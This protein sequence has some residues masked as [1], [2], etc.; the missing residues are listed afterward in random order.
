MNNHLKNLVVYQI[1]P[2]TFHDSNNDGIGDLNGI[3]TKISYFKN[4]GINA[5]WLC[6]IF[7]SPM[8]DNGYD[9]SNYRKINAIYGT[10]K[11]FDNLV[12]TCK[13]SGIRV[14]LD[15]VPNHTSDQHEWFKKFLNNDEKFQNY[16]VSLEK[17]PTNTVSVFG[18]KSVSLLKNNHWLLHTFGEQQ[19]DVNWNNPELR[20]EFIDITNYWIKKGIGGFRFDVIDLIGKKI[21]RNNNPVIDMNKTHRYVQE[22][23]KKSWLNN[24]IVTVGESWNRDCKQINLYSDPNRNELSML[25]TFVHMTTNWTKSKWELS[26]F[27]LVKFKKIIQKQQKIT[28][29]KGMPTLFLSNHDFPRQVSF[30]GSHVYLKQ[31]AITLAI[32]MHFLRGV[33]FIFN[34]EEIGMTNYP[35]DKLSDFRDLETINTSDLFK[36][37]EKFLEAAKLISRDNARTTMQWNAD[38]NGGFSQKKH[39]SLLTNPNYQQINVDNQIKEKKSIWHWYQKLIAFRTTKNNLQNLLFFGE[40]KFRFLKH[41]NIFAYERIYRKQ[42]IMA[43]ANWSDNLVKLKLPKFKKIII[44]TNEEKLTNFLKPWQTVVIQL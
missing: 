35:F 38:L 30:F 12:K 9:V 31:S 5:I 11:D 15:I 26:D 2:L 28:F 14:I 34:G 3:T 10:E 27:N 36:D 42:R 23:A 25:F 43:L 40:T 19:I 13:K 18:T 39:L 32:T 16:Y 20:K 24:D 41:P 44:N 6:P 29:K 7:E 21:D 37:K 17:K 4:L 33:P 8:K 1:Y 22:W